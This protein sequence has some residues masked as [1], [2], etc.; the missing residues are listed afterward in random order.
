MHM[1]PLLMARH[2][3]PSTSTSRSGT[4]T[5]K[6]APHFH[7]TVYIGLPTAPS[8][9]STI[10]LK[11][12]SSLRINRTHT[13]IR[14]THRPRSKTGK[15]PAPEHWILPSHDALD[16]GLHDAED[17]KK[18]VSAVLD[19]V[20]DRMSKALV[21]E[22]WRRG[23]MKGLVKVDGRMEREMERAKKEK[24]RKEVREERE[25]AR[26]E[27]GRRVGGVGLGISLGW[28][29]GMGMGR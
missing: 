28:G 1:Y 9:P 3:S 8:T 17:T 19:K 26:R 20:G 22:M 13:T 16:L 12:L 27:R 23:G 4:P 6:R 7:H 29:I 11:T 24:E 25:E 2:T 14:F 10:V 15:W 21:R 5:T 18:V